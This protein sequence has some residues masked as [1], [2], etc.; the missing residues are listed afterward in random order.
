MCTRMREIIS[1]TI[2]T[3]TS[4]CERERERGR[5]RGERERCKNAEAGVIMRSGYENG[6]KK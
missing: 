5:E 2:E 1:M 6:G 4:K 3:C